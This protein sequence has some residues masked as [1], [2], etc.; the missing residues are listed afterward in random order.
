[1]NESVDSD[2][3]VMPSSSGRPVAGRPPSRNDTLVLFEETELVHL[4]VDEELGVA[5]VFDLHPPHHLADDDLDVL[6]VDVDALQPVDLLDFVDQVALQRLFAEHVEDVVR[7]AR[8]IHQCL[9]G[10]DALPFLHVDMNAARQRVLA[11]LAAALVGHDDD[12]A[13][14]LDDAP[15]ADHAVDLA[16]DGGLAGLARLEQLDHARQTT[17]DV[18]RLGRLA[19]DLRQHVTRKH[20]LAVAHHQVR[21]HRHV[22]L[23]GDFCRRV[24]LRIHGPDFHR[25]L[26]LLV[27]RIHDDQPRESGDLVDFLMDGHAFDDVLESDLAGFLGQNRE[28]VRIPFD[29]HL[30]LLDLLPVFHAQTGA[31][32][33]RIALAVTPFLVLHDQ[34]SGAIHDDESTV[35]G[36][37]DLQPLQ[38]RGPG[39]LRLE[40]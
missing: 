15:V 3:F 21:M 5:D 11:R 1:M 24:A 18:L 13:L 26:L 28:R 22:I 20:L 8:P 33:D 9:T 35:L 40:G 17:G 32:H 19:R 27:R 38:S 10:P 14:T 16:D 25:R 2:A 29:Q 36:L 4:L 12:L 7:V 31:V 6:V 34:R 37:D 39:V 30:T 23:P